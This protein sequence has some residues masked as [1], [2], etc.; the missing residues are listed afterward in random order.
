MLTEMPLNM[1]TLFLLALSQF[2][3]EQKNFSYDFYA[4]PWSAET[5]LV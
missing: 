1:G 4:Q 3:I 2:K 5:S